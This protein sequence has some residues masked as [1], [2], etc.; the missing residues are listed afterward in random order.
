ME[1]IQ[2]D[3]PRW[4][5]VLCSPKQ[6]RIGDANADQL[7]EEINPNYL[8][9]WRRDLWGRGAILFIAIFILA[10]SSFTF[11]PHLLFP[12]PFYKDGELVVISEVSKII[13]IIVDLVMVLLPALFILL[14]LF[15]PRY[16]DTYFDRKHRK[17]YGWS[18]VF[19]GRWT[20]L[21]FDSVTAV[22]QV[23][24]HYHTAGRTT[25]YALWLCEI[26]P[27]TNRILK[28]ISVI[29]PSRVAEV[30]SQIW[31]FCRVYMNSP[32]EK[33]PPVELDLKPQTIYEHFWFNN[34][35]LFGFMLDDNGKLQGSISRFFTPFFG[36]FFYPMEFGAILLDKVVPSRRLPPELR[37]LVPWQ[38]DNPYRLKRATPDERADINAEGKADQV[39]HIISIVLAFAFWGLLLWLMTRPR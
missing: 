17:I 30:P 32:I 14:A 33:V 20:I 10:F 22:S 5:Q 29:Y 11:L 26:D 3:N 15:S 37:E 27:K 8:S 4:G 24:S 28:R 21:D 18:G 25:L 35:R 38:G 1:K 2:F 16:P 31:D 34:R 36:M 7:A 39:I 6:E 19:F 9:F 13:L 12:K 23:A